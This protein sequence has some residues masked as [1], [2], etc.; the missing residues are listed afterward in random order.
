MI[1][2]WRAVVWAAILAALAIWWIGAFTVA[3]WIVE[4]IW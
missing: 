1:D 4:A 2:V 3:R